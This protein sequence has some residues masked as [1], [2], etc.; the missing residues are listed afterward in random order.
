MCMCMCVCVRACVRECV[1]ACVICVCMCM[2][3]RHIITIIN[4]QR[5]MDLLYSGTGR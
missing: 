5:C 3:D 1:R 4:G 2:C